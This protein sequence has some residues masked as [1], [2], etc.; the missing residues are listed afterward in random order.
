MST[1]CGAETR[2]ASWVV[3]VASFGYLSRHG[4]HTLTKARD[5]ATADAVAAQQQGD[6][7]RDEMTG[8]IA[9]GNAPAQD[10]GE[11]HEPDRALEP[12]DHPP[13]DLD[14]EQA[15]DRA[16]DLGA[17]LGVVDAGALRIGGPSRCGYGSAF[18][19][20]S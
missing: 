8:T 17:Q 15:P 13:R 10:V 2:L 12:L 1:A 3:V 9:P 11:R 5:A 19:G 18:P 4:L 16:V 6:Q 7:P 14:G 20:C